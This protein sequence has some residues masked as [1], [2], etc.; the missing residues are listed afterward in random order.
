MS[1]QGTTHHCAMV[2]KGGKCC[3]AMTMNKVGCSAIPYVFG[4]LVIIGLATLIV[5]QSKV[6]KA[7]EKSFKKK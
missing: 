6:L 4:A 1:N 5:L 2:E 7:L 3:E